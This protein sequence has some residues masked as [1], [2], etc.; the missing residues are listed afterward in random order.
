MGIPECL[1][2]LT[3]SQ[4]QDED[5]DLIQFWAEHC[6]YSLR[7]GMQEYQSTLIFE[8]DGAHRADAIRY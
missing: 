8:T 5:A 4:I 2:G 3:R 6:R 7:H 1:S